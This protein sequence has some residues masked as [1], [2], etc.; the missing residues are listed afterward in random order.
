[1][2]DPSPQRSTVL[3]ITDTIDEHAHAVRDELI[4]HDAAVWIWDV[5]GF[6]RTTPFSI[7][8]DPAAGAPVRGTLSINEGEL[9]LDTVTAVWMRR[10]ML[11]L[12]APR[13]Q[14]DDV[15]VFVGFELEAAFRGIADTLRNARWV[16]PVDALYAIEPEVAQKHAAQAAGLKLAVGEPEVANVAIVVVGTQVFDFEYELPVEV[17]AACLRL[18]HAAG[19]LL[20]SI[21]LM[22]SASDR[23]SFVQMKA[24]PDWLQLEQAT[25]EAITAAIAGVLVG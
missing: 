3:I 6:P 7:H 15:G 13:E 23:Y 12:F 21:E 11:G 1:M 4:K 24:N 17:R 16:N 8:F 5:G 2:P 20:A 18:V 19:L 22:R 14:P 10:S 9:S 25:G